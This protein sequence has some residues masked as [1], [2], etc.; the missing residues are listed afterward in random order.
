MFAFA[1]CDRSDR[2]L[3][4]A[5]DRIGVKPLYW[6]WQGDTLFFGSQ[7]RAFPPSGMGT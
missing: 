7:M 6:G 1:L 3:Y 4:L 5:S 2:I